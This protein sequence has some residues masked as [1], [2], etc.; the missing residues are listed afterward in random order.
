MLF[1]PPTLLPLSLLILFVQSLSAQGDAFVFDGIKA[2]ESVHKIFE[3]SCAECHDGVS[4]SRSK[5]SFGT[6]MDF[7]AM[8]E[9]PD[10][11]VPGNAEDSEVYLLIIDEDPDF[12]MPPLDSE[13]PQLSKFE[14]ELVKFWI[15]SGA[16]SPVSATT[17]IEPLEADPQEEEVAETE[18]KA[19]DWNY[20]F[21][22]LHPLVIHFPIALVLVAFA[23]A[24]AGQ[25]KLF[26]HTDSVITWCLAFGA[27]ISL[28]SVASGWINADVS[29]YSDESVFNHRWS[30]VAVAIG[31]TIA[32]FAHLR[33]ITSGSK[34]MH[35]L[36]WVAII[37]S[38]I[39]VSIA[40]H[41][42][43]E[44]VYGEESFFKQ[45]FSKH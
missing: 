5:G 32:L 22:K 1:R 40:G 15:D 25:L 18:T 4:R 11:L 42:G 43:G 10:L 35:A 7:D 17:E 23:A 19:K 39:S 24:L 37:A 30:G 36:F 41:T 20:I 14:A 3:R 44:L 38:V 45:I 8:R 27:A 34:A 33:K 6:V 21:G 26:K 2:A 12:V 31:A 9:D 16:P 13:S 29:G 28:I